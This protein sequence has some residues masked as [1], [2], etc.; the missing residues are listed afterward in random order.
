MAAPAAASPGPPTRRSQHGAARAFVSDAR[1]ATTAAN[2]LRLLALRRL[3]GTSPAEANAL[4]F[5][6]ALTAADASLRGAR[7]AT[8]AAVPSRGDAAIGGFLVR[9]AALGIA[10]PAAREF[11]FVGS[12][13]AAAMIA[14][15]ALPELRRAAHVLR[16]AEHRVREQRIRVYAAAGR[17]AQR[18]G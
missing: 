16:V 13:L 7:R 4:T 12:L 1:L 15:I 18:A 14:G 5:V 3:F 8:R 9:D 6:L 10:G 17:P 2:Q 11:P